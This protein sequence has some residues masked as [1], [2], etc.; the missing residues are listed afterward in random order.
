M[1]NEHSPKY[2]Q[3]KKYYETGRWSAASV[4]K[5]VEK[6]WI[7]QEECAEILGENGAE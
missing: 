2:E 1:T 5:A 6:G 4:R 3:I 7:T